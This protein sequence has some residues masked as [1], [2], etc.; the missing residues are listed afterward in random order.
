MVFLGKKKEALPFFGVTSTN[1]FVAEIEVIIKADCIV[2]SCVKLKRG[3]CND[4]MPLQAK[5]NLRVSEV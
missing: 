2:D 5:M 1:S 3:P 4:N